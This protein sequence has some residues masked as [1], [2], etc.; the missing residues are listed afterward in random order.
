MLMLAHLQM[1][2]HRCSLNFLRVH[3]APHTWLSLTPGVHL[4]GPPALHETVRAA[5]AEDELAEGRCGH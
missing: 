4:H 5:T 2:A 3:T 1:S